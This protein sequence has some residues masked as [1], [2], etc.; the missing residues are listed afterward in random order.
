M[1]ILHLADV[2][3]DRPFVGLPHAAA[4]ARRQELKD[5][6][7]RS[8]DAAREHE[9]D[10]VTIGGDLWEDENVTPDTRASVAHLLGGVDVP[11]AIVCGNH[12]P[13]LPGG[14][15]VRTS[16]PENVHLFTQSTP[17]ELPLE[18]ISIWGVSWTG[19]RARCRVPRELSNP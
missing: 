3:L 7:S 19:G 4:E 5:A 8:L 9:V 12:D 2:H 14:N 1:R 6:L 18:E 16:W 13:Y 17:T 15:Y 10:L 11:V